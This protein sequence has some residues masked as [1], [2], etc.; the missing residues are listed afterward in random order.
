MFKPQCCQLQ[1]LRLLGTIGNDGGVCRQRRLSW[2][3]Y[4]DGRQVK[5]KLTDDGSYFHHL[6]DQDSSKEPSSF[7]SKVALQDNSIISLLTIVV[8]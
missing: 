8:V 1:E 7:Q 2:V 3:I 4:F 5:H 6:A